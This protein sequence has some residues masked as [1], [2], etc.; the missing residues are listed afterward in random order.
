VL[1]LLFGVV[2]CSLSVWWLQRPDTV[3]LG[4][5]ALDQG[6]VAAARRLWESHLAASPDD[7]RLRMELAALYA[8][9]VPETAIGH[10]EQIS[11]DSAQYLT[12]VRHIAFLSIQINDFPRAEA[13]LHVLA[14]DD[15]EEAA[16]R[17]ALAELYFRNARY[18]AAL[19]EARAAAG[20]QPDRAGTHLLIAEILD[21]L[22]RVSEMAA[23]LQAALE[24]D[25]ES[26]PVHANLAYA[27]HFEGELDAARN[28][29]E[30]CLSR[31]GDDFVV[32]RILAG[33]LRDQGQTEAA[34][35]QVRRALADAPDDLK[36]RLLEADLLLYDGQAG[37]AWERLLPL[38]EEHGD[39]RE[40]LA[41]LVR[42]AF[43][44]GHL[45]EGRVYQRELLSLIPE[46]GVDD[47]DGLGAPDR[48]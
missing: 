15:P 23:P 7:D 18:R 20:L 35:A 41:G 28:E 29:A 6:D 12:A 34:L 43:A 25:P 22:D 1:L 21:E 30:W 38:Y 40:F 48:E 19:P 5:R 24:L 14:R 13:A 47:D 8:E 11:P 3:E 26:Y 9:D 2:I 4:Q 17:L 36:C 31:R 16:V 39:N 45:D 33:I 32:R 37:A 42:A 44:S 27:L 10:Y 46:R